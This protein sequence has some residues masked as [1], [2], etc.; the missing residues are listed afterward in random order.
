MY[1]YKETEVADADNKLLSTIVERYQ[2]ILDEE[3]ELQS[4]KALKNEVETAKKE[5]EALMRDKQSAM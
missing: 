4:K 5:H 2:Q 1:D 3:I